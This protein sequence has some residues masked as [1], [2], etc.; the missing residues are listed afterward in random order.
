VRANHEFTN[1]MVAAHYKAQVRYLTD[2]DCYLFLK[3]F[4]AC[5]ANL[6]WMFELLGYEPSDTRK[7]WRMARSARAAR[8][9]EI[10]YYLGHMSL[11]DMSLLWVLYST[12]VKPEK[13]RITAV[14]RF[15]SGS[16]EQADGSAAVTTRLAAFW[17]KR[18]HQVRT[19]M[20]TR[21]QKTPLVYIYM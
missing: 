9:Y 19:P 17:F 14:F 15:A 12:V 5:G 1:W 3:Q 7:I 11:L 10:G 16:M 21:I 13:I 4:L 8:P 20:M 18:W 2:Y 6:F